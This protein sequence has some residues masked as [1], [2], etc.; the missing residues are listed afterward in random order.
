MRKIILLLG[1]IIV[2]NI[3]FVPVAQAKDAACAIWLCLPAGFPSGCG[4]A[5]RE[6]K[7]RIKKFKP[8]LPRLSSCLVNFKGDGKP[9][10][11]GFSGKDGYAAYIPPTRVCV[12]SEYRGSGSDRSRYCVAYKKVPEKMIRGTRCI[13]EKEQGEAVRTRPAGCT[14]TYRYVT[15]LQH[16]KVF[17]DHY[18]FR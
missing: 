13:R 3:G 12:K 6:F 5:K 15:V 14:T 11:Q 18:Y 9:D 17:G 1:S 16:G 8:P 7:K 10:T 4:D 2:L